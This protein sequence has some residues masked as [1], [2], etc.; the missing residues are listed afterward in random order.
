LKY[1]KKTNKMKTWIKILIALILIGII[2]GILGYFF[3]YN[4][5]HKDYS[6]AKAEISLTAEELYKS[7]IENTTE[8]EQRFNGKVLEI[9]GNL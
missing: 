8:A 4:K 6:K 7:F 9:E 2:A 5:P 3:V 1:T